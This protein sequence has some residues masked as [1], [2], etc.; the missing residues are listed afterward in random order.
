MELEQNWDGE[1]EQRWLQMD[2]EQ[3]GD[4]VGTKTGRSRA[5]QDKVGAASDREIEY[6]TYLLY[7]CPQSGD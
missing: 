5:E 1:M 2:Q 6:L 7:L 4:R 3:T